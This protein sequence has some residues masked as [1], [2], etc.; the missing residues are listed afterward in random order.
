M[1][2][3]LGGTVIPRL[4]GKY[5]IGYRREDNRLVRDSCWMARLHA[6]ALQ[7]IYAS[8]SKTYPINDALLSEV[9]Q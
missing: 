3:R 1:V 5:S 6:Q 4:P 7:G 9:W 2:E 8:L